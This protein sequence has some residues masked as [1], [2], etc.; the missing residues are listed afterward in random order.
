VI[1]TERTFQS[2]LTG[3]FKQNAIQ[4]AA[5]AASYYPDAPYQG[6]TII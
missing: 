2:P 4:L 1:G 3:L 5:S 6:L